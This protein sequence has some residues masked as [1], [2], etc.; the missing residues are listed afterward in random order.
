MDDA[1]HTIDAT[2]VRCLV[3]L[4]AEL[5]GTWLTNAVLY[6]QYVGILSEAR[7]ASSFVGVVTLVA[8]A[9]WALKRPSSIN[10]QTLTAASFVLFSAGFAL[11]VL[12]ISQ[13]SATLLLV[14]SCVRSVGSRWVVVLMG[15]SLCKLGKRSCMLCIASAWWQAM[16]CAS[17]S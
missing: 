7:D 17:R 2:W 14:G 5:F 10:E 16:C 11:I 3:A 8:L 6:P 12:G 4:A 1:R 13:Q 15:I 9:V